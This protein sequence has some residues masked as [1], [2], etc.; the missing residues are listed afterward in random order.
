MDP[1]VDLQAQIIALRMA[2]EGAWLTLLQM[3]PNGRSAATRLRRENVAAVNQ[4]DA[5]TPESKAL[6]DAVAG[7]VDKFWGS[8]GWQLDPA[9]RQ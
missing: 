1:I 4:L 2:A 6:R 9:N 8:V 7:S 3:D 5:T